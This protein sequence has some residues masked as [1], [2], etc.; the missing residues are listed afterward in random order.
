MKLFGVAA[1]VLALTGPVAAQQGAQGNQPGQ[2][3]NA[4]AAQSTSESQRTPA[5][6]SQSNRAADDAQQ[7][8]RDAAGTSGQNDSELPATASPFPAIGLLGFLSLAGA[9]FVRRVRSH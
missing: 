4:A 8:G 6:G 5:T 1:L 9:A 2:D 3:A 7:D